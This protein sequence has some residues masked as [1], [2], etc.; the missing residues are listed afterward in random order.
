MIGVNNNN[1]ILFFYCSETIGDLVE[2][3]CFYV[4]QWQFQGYLL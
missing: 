1:K 3:N 2:R 4:K